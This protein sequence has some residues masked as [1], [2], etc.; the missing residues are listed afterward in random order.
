[1]ATHLSI[2]SQHWSFVLDPLSWETERDTDFLVR[3]LKSD[4]PDAPHGITVCT[5]VFELMIGRLASCTVVDIQF[6]NAEMLKRPFKK[7]SLSNSSWLKALFVVV[8]WVFLRTSSYALYIYIYTDCYICISLSQLAS[9]RDGG[10]WG[11]VVFRDP[12][13]RGR[14]CWV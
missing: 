2:N 11:I 4:I 3:S 5:F 12:F 10:L 1:M 6:C 9:H 14:S 7:R 8:P 13:F